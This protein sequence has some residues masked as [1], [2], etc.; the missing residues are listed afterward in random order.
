MTRL[1]LVLLAVLF[2]AA[3]PFVA[4]ADKEEIKATTKWVGLY[5][6]NK[7]DQLPKD[8]RETPIGYIGDAKTFKAV[9]TA[10]KKDDK[11]PE[12]DFKKNVV[13]FTRNTQF[14]NRINIAKITLEDGKLDLLAIETRTATKIEDKVH[15]AMAVVPRKGIKSIKVGDKEIK[16][17]E[18]KEEK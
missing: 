1:C 14:L 10:W 9:W 18:A 2:L 5:P 3:V 17:A 8:Q 4:A 11:L 6:T 13:I 15:M 7:L 12:V 16:V